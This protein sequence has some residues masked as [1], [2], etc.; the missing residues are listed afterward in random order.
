MSNGKPTVITPRSE[1]SMDAMIIATGWITDLRL[2]QEVSE[3]QDK[4]ALWADKFNPPEDQS[5]EALLR[6]PYLG[7]GFNFIEKITGTAPYINSIFNCTGGAL[8]STGFSAGTG[9]T[10]MRYS[11]KNLVYELVSQLFVEDK[12][13][14]YYTLDNYDNYLFEN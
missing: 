9:I 11:V 14:Y 2:R 6:A 12:D 5:Y 4:I 10:G 8:V 3:F 7:K 1:D 13:Y